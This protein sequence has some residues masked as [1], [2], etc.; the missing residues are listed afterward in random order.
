MAGGNAIQ[1]Y[2]RY[3]ALGRVSMQ[4]LSEPAKHPMPGQENRGQVPDVRGDG[5]PPVRRLRYVEDHGA[6]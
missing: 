6:G 5:F 3:L 2:R 1:L 4:R